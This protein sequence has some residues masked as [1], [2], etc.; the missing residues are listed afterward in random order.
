VRRFAGEQFLQS[1][2]S[3]FRS[4][5]MADEAHVVFVFIDVEALDGLAIGIEVDERVPLE[6]TDI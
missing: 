2:K 1:I 6:A 4:A 3:V 5:I